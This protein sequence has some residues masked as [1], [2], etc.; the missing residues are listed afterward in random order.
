MAWRRLLGDPA[1][2]KYVEVVCKSG[3]LSKSWTLYSVLAAV[4]VFCRANQ[5]TPSEMIMILKSSENCGKFFVNFLH[6]LR[7]QGYTS[8]T[9]RRYMSGLKDF[10]IFHNAFSSKEWNYINRLKRRIFGRKL[11][12]NI[13]SSREGELTQEMIRDILIEGCRSRRER[14]MVLVMATSGMSF[15]DLLERKIGDFEDLWKEQDCYMVKYIRKKSGIKTTTFI[16]PETRGWILKY[17]TERKKKGEDITKDSP[18]LV[19]E[20]GAP[21][22]RG[23]AIKIM[24]RIFE[25]A[26][27]NEVIGIDAGG[28]RRYMYHPSLLRKY[29]R[30]ALQNAGI[31][32]IYVEAMMGHDIYSMFRL[33]MIYDKRPQDIEVLRKQYIK[34]LPELTFLQPVRRGGV[35]IT[36]EELERLNERLKLFEIKLKI[37]EIM[38]KNEQSRGDSKKRR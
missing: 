15:A 14:V 12:S 24:R 32:R 25:R 7:S 19:N 1:V 11:T 8:I 6:F 33:E 21:L 3:G 36:T 38:L 5:L 29:F 9:I 35:F 2:E 27:L 28:R 13:Y 18:L 31:D 26:E 16:T 10:L 30:T 37:L 34:A 22:A 4:D 17:L 23:T 20:N